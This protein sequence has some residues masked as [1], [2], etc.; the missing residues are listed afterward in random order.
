MAVIS[1]WTNEALQKF[2][3]EFGQRI[4][5]IAL[6][7][8]RYL[9]IG[10]ESSVQLKDIELVNKY[11]MDLMKVH[12]KSNYGGKEIEWD[13]YIT[14]TLIEGIEVMDEKDK[15]YRIDPIMIK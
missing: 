4:N 9:W 3:D 6:N 12:H 10:Y 5:S 2:I 7:N 14:T 15:F 13:N 1:Q 8:G 11:G